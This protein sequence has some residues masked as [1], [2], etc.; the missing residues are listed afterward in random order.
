V[1]RNVKILIADEPSSWM[2]DFAQDLDATHTDMLFEETEQRGFEII[3][4]GHLDLALIA[5]DVPRLGG[6][7][8]VRR[9]HWFSEEL[10]VIVLGGQM[11]IRWLSEAM[12]IGVRTILPRPVNI[13]RL[14]DVSIKILG[15]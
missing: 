4:Q 11:D 5:A 14:V 13:D 3:R 2:E 7:E 1:E 6:L 15:F 8:F 12:R 10:P 9:V